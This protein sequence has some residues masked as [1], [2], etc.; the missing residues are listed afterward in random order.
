[1]VKKLSESDD[2]RITYS[3]SFNVTVPKN[4]DDLKMKDQIN[5]LITQNIGEITSIIDVTQV[6][7]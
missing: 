2:N 6:I 3:V 5:D 1:M 4:T 7:E